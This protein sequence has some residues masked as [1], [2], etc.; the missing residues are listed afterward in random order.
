L[1]IAVLHG[2]KKETET[3]YLAK[4]ADYYPLVTGKVFIYRLDSTYLDATATQLLVNSYLVEDSI[5]TV[6]NDNAGRPSYPVY[7]FIT[8]TLNSAP[9]QALGTYYI[10]ETSQTAEVVD[11]NNL[12]FIKLKAP[13]NEGA[14]WSGNSYIDTRSATSPYQYM[15][16]WNY[17]CQNVNMPFTTLKGSLDSTV[18]V[19]QVDDTSPP[20][21]FDAA[22]YQQRNYSLEVYAKGIGLVYKDFLHWTWQPDPPPA[23][24]QKDSYGFRLN[25]IDVR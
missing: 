6:F 22:S 15:D 12:R 18:T 24:Y 2:C 25:L 20:G 7:R 23:Q 5:G 19:L 1:F 10:T 13:L 8:D 14:A 4:P 21:P 16:G 3:L 9:W 11:D 17:T